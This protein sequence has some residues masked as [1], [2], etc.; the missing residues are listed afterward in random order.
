MERKGLGHQTEA[1]LFSINPLERRFYPQPIYYD[2]FTRTKRVKLLIALVLPKTPPGGG[3]YPTSLSRRLPERS[4]G[5]WDFAVL[6]HQVM[7][8]GTRGA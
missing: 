1:L 8:R 6:R 2:Y 3:G 5:P 4:G 7:G